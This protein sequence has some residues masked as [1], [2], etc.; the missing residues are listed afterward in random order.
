MRFALL[1]ASTAQADT[2]GSGA[3]Q[4]SIEFVPIGNPNNPD[5]TTG[6]PNPAGKVEYAYRMG[7]YEISRDMI[8][9]ANSE[10]SLGITMHPMG[11]VTGGAR[12]DMPATGVSW[13]E[14]ATFVNWLNDSQG[15]QK[16]Y[17]F[18]GSGSFQLWT[19]SEAW[20]NGGE[21]LFRHKDAFYFLPSMDEW[22]K[23]AYYDPSGVYFDY[24]TGS[25]SVPTPVA[26]GTLADTAVYSQSII[27]GPADF[28]LAGG[29]SPYGTMGQGGNV[30]EWEETEFDLQNDSSSSARG[31]RGISWGSISLFLLSSFR[32][33]YDPSIEDVNVGFRVAS[34]PE[35]SSLLMG[36]L[37]TGGLL[38]RRRRLS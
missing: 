17:N 14:A 11:F 24:P 36:A 33:S 29:L 28:T 18:D 15:Y 23:A 31:V 6:T 13:F 5:D 16:A 12:A 22:Y 8:T 32:F 19:S 7:K 4:F 37:A 35:P 20:Q 27:Q 38:M 21:N 34:I 26:S 9:K 30:W 3:N 1:Y 25:D 10:G 2:F